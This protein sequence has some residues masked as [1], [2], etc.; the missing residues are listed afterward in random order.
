MTT[1]AIE[2]LKARAE[3]AEWF[4]GMYGRLS[5][6]EKLGEVE[7]AAYTDVSD[8]FAQI[9]QRMLDAAYEIDDQLK[10]PIDGGRVVSIGTGITRRVA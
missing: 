4:A 10:L 3:S 7:R 9:Q 6:D 2:H 5:D 1:P 8:L